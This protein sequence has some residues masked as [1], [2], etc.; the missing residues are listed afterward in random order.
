ML[1]EPLSVGETAVSHFLSDRQH[2]MSRLITAFG[3]YPYHGASVII[4]DTSDCN[5]SR[6][7][8]LDFQLNQ[9]T[10]CSNFSSLLLVV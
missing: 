7:S 1:V 4:R 9:P 3:T 5:L 8:K 2:V 6:I 10:R